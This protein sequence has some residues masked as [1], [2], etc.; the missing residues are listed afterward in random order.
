MSRPYL[1]SQLFYQIERGAYGFKNF[2][3]SPSWAEYRIHYMVNVSLQILLCRIS[4][5]EENLVENR[6]KFVYRVESRLP[7]WNIQDY[8]R[9]RR[10][11]YYV[12]DPACCDAHTPPHSRY[13]NSMDWTINVDVGHVVFSNI[14]LSYLLS[15]NMQRLL[16]WLALRDEGKEEVLVKGWMVLRAP[17]WA[18][19]TSWLCGECGRGG[20]ESMCRIS[21]AGKK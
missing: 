3:I 15:S 11:Y 17:W 8:H 13:P 18:R 20:R 7:F 6:I 16:F 9:Q 4:S 12:V 19:Q 14:K 2:R 10:S 5:C 1:R 21:V